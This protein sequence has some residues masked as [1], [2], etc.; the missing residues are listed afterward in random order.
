MFMLTYSK[1]HPIQMQDECKQ[2]GQGDACQVEGDK[3]DT[4]AD[5]LLTASS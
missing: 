2:H 1:Y 4:R 5:L 3:I